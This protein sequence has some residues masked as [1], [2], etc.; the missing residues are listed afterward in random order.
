[1]PWNTPTL[2]RVRELVRDDVTAALGGI[3]LIGNNPLRVVSDAEAGMAHLNL[4]YID[5]LA[6]QFIPD[7]AEKEWLDRHAAI[8]LGGRKNATLSYGQVG[9][10]GTVGSVLPQWSRMM[11]GDG[12]EFETLEEATIGEDGTSVADT[13]AVTPGSGNNLPVG[14]NLSIVT[15]PVGVNGSAAVTVA[16][17]GGTDIETDDELRTRVL[18]RIR[19]PPMGGDASDYVQWA[20]EVPGCTRAWTAPLEMGMGTVT[21]RVMFDDLRATDDPLTNGFPLEEDLVAVRNHIDRVRPVTTKDFWVYGPI[22]EP[23]DFTIQDL[24]EDDAD[25]RGAIAASVDAM[26]RE[27]AA[28]SY[29]R[30]GV[31][32]EAQTIYAAWVS[33]A[34][35]NTPDVEH[36]RLVMLDHP[37]PA[38]GYM[39]VR[40]TITYEEG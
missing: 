19:E 38:P 13:R 17:T 16:F 2:R 31:R 6:L 35:L 39:G 26:L 32:Q 24:V 18:L 10:T 25:T 14:S 20:L 9:L 33:D 12:F 23:I 11:G 8:W 3:T 36:F 22:P 7:T 37:M 34:I 21:V 5:W 1:M 28:P 15:A 30:D 29:S 4:R 27:R 40:G